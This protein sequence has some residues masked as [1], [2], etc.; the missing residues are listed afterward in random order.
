MKQIIAGL[1]GIVAL[2]TLCSCATTA[3]PQL[4]EARQ[5]YT[6]STSGLTA[7][8]TPTEL[9]DSKKALDQANANFE[10][11]GDNPKTRDYAYIALRKVQTA[12]TKARTEYD[13][14]QIYEA[15]KAGVKVR[16]MQLILTKEELEAERRANELATAELEKEKGARQAA[17]ASLQS[18]LT[19][20]AAVASIKEESRGTVITLSGSVLFASG[21]YALLSGAK[22]RLDQVAAAIKA[23]PEE[24]RITVEGHTDSKGKAASNEVLSRNRAEAVREYLITQGVSGD[25]ITAVGMGPRRPIVENNTAENRANNRRVEIIIG[26]SPNVSVR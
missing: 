11:E 7:K 8:L 23:G 6:Q 17:E 5:A 12:D 15:S 2:S 10:K 24:K 22:S 13:R 14:R 19:E 4:V 9:Y 25:R 21:K 18:A 1:I 20:L 3:P 26:D 16:D